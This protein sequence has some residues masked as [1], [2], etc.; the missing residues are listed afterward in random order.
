MLLGLRAS[1]VI[2]ENDVS[3]GVRVF[4]GPFPALHRG[5]HEA[6]HLVLE[7]G[8]LQ[9]VLK[10]IEPVLKRRH[11]LILIF[12]DHKLVRGQTGIDHLPVFIIGH[13]GHAL[14]L[15]LQ[16]RVD[17]EALLQDI[18]A[19]A[20]AVGRDAK[21]A[22]PGQE[23][24]L[25]AI[26]PDAKGLA[27]EIRRRL[28][29]GILAAGQ[30]HARGFERL[31]NVDQVH[32]LFARGKRR[33]HPVDDDIRATAR[34]HL[35]GRYI[36]ATR[37]DGDIKILFRIEALVRSNEISGELGLGHPLQLQRQLV[38]STCRRAHGNGRRKRQ[39]GC[40]CFFH[41]MLPRL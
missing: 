29:A 11:A 39:Q 28:D 34:D 8:V 1:G 4:L 25:V 22:H 13:G 18:Y 21:L 24:I 23:R 33:R 15:L 31:G 37:L 3:G 38:C 14:G 5:P 16:D 9:T 2:L 17:I 32:T 19:A 7:G 10:D 41:V 27:A 35:N 12:E 6:N 30:H 36:G 26:E 20:A 40:Q